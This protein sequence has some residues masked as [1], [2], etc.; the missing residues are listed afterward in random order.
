MKALNATT[1]TFFTGYIA[2]YATLASRD[3]VSIH[4]GYKRYNGSNSIRVSSE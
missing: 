1:D 3:V 2:M 4:G